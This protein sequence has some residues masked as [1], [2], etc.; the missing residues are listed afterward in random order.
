MFADASN[1]ANGNTALQRQLVTK[2]KRGLNFL[3][4]LFGLWGLAGKQSR[5]FKFAL[6]S[7]D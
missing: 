1:I 2:N 3:Q 5:L 4:T 7:Y 6:T